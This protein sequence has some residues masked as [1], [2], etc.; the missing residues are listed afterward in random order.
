MGAPTDQPDR[1]TYLLMSIG[2]S[3]SCLIITVGA[4]M[5][6]TA[7]AT[8]STATIGTG[9]TVLIAIPILRLLVMAAV[10]TRTRELALLAI[11][12]AVLGMLVATATAGTI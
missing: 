1:A 6:Y 9:I 2:S 12:L 11:T 4:I 5:H 7:W 10:F 3:L 8:A